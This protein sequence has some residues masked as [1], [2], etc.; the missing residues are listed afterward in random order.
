MRKMITIAATALVL[1]LI[2]AEVS[3]GIAYANEG[4]EY[5][6]GA[7]STLYGSKWQQR[8]W[9]ITYLQYALGD[10]YDQ[11]AAQGNYEVVDWYW[12]ENYQVW[13]PI[14][15]WVADYGQLLSYDQNWYW[16]TMTYKIQNAEN[17]AYH[18]TAEVFYYGHMGMQLI[19]GTS[20]YRFA[21][22]ESGEQTGSEPSK[23]WDNMVYSYTNDNYDF[24]LLWVC[25]NANAIGGTSPAIYGMPYCWFHRTLGSSGYSPGD[26]G[27]DCFIS[28]TGASPCIGDGMG[29]Y[30]QNG[31]NLYKHWL[32]FFY[33]FALNGYSIKGALEQ[34]SYM[35]GYNNYWLDSNNRLSQGWAYMF[36]G[37]VGGNEPP[38][39]PD[40]GN[41]T[42]QMLVYGNANIY[43][44]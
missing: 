34:A 36:P 5:D 3:F 20:T 16:S 2:T 40:A 35:V 9:D 6:Y 33:Y 7:A 30:N 23:I 19:P 13:F 43:L 37:W 10:I 18:S 11:F 27:S 41:Y 26:G 31:E 15:E 24:A 38:D 22:H 29:T 39:W 28:F 14:Y 25:N 1:A 42:G 4:Y 21:F 12:D 17:D 32:V 8:T 44:P